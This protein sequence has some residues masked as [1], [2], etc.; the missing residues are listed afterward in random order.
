MFEMLNSTKSAPLWSSTMEPTN[1]TENVTAWLTKAPKII[2]NVVYHQIMNIY[3]LMGI[4]LAG[5]IMNGL[6][7]AVMRDKAFNKLPLSVYFTSLA[8]SDSGMLVMS[9]VMQYMKEFSPG[10]KNFFSVAKYC[11]TLG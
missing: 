10:R 6:V 5:L 8:V 3:L 11:A 2:E 1:T 9:A 4:T 7:V